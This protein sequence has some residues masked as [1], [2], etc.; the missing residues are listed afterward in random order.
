MFILVVNFLTIVLRP[1]FFNNLFYG[2]YFEKIGS[3][4]EIKININDI[5]CS[6]GKKIK[7]KTVFF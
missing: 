3:E 6:V 2:N 1:E 5:K 4:E 7:N